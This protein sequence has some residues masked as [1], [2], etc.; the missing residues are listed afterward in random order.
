MGV[1]S[2]TPFESTIPDVQVS[3]NIFILGIIFLTNK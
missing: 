2:R 3:T 1:K